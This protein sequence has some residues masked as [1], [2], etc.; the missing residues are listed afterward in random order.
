MAGSLIALDRAAR[1]PAK[2]ALV[3]TRYL[4][5]PVKEVWPLVSTA[6]GISRWWVAPVK[7]LDLRPGGVF[8]HHWK[9][10]VSSFEPLRLIDFNEAANYDGTGGLRFEIV[11]DG[12]GQTRFVLLSTFGPDVIAEGKEPQPHG[13]GT[14]WAGVASGWHGAADALEAIF[15]DRVSV[16]DWNDLMVFY[17]EYLAD[18]FN[19]IDMVKRT[20]G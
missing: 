15:D 5:A 14:V 16:P 12:K 17:Q 4:Q 3:Y 2:H 20:D 18:Q 1:I 19:Y 9:N 11:P 13:P 6:E 8:D 7:S 10:T